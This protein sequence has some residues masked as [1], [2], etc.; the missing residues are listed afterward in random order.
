MPLQELPAFWKPSLAG[1]RRVQPEPLSDPFRT[2]SD[3][4]PIRRRRRPD[5]EADGL[6]TVE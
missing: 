1:S 3:P 5:A 2:V 6:W 4:Q